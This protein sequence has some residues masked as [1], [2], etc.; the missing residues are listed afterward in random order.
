MP[1]QIIRNDITRVAADAIV[2]TANPDP[3]VGN[4]TDRAIYQ[5][6]GME[7][8]LAA[9][10]QIGPIAPGE[11]AVTPGFRLPAKYILHTV[12]PIWRGGH[13][14]ELDIL[15]A[16]YRNCLQLADQLGCI[17]IAFPLISTGVYGF[18]KDQALDIAL[19]AIRAHLSGSDLDVTLVVFGE[20]AY[21][22]A[23]GLTEK[24]DAYIDA[25]Y[26]AAQR[27]I[28]Y[29]SPSSSTVVDSRTWAHPQEIDQGAP[30]APK[31]GGRVHRRRRGE[32]FLVG[33]RPAP[34]LQDAVSAL[35]E[36]LLKK[37]T[38]EE[39]VVNLGESFQARLLRM[40]DERG[41]SDPAV[42]KRANIDRKLF[43]KIRCSDQYIPKKKTIVALAIALELNLDD[44]KDLL[45]SAG[46]TL[47]NNVLGDVIVQFCIEQHIY[48][49]FEIN[50][51]LFKYGQPILGQ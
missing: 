41:L 40:I 16:C 44:T 15:R 3:V 36:A 49:I 48:D 27:E 31:A 7:Q 1:F 32:P 8:L 13:Q 43:S 39:A 50:A 2:N 21:Q 5:A 38:L 51:M 30:P 33:K 23:A 17:R 26:V 46:L 24:V 35:P 20:E 45:A 42:Y 25:H 10:K 34:L 6:A 47:T 37:R 14:G 12:G 4:G 11:V 19:S 28:E 9:R 22:L 18:P 29:G